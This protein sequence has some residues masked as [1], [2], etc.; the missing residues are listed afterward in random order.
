[1]KVRDFL[2]KVL[3][4]SIKDKYFNALPSLPADKD[5]VLE[6]FI[7][8]LNELLSE[9]GKKNPA[10]SSY[11]YDTSA[12]KRDSDL[13]VDYLRPKKGNFLT[14]FSVEF[15][16]SGGTVSYPLK[17][18]GISDF[19]ANS[20][21][22]TIQTLPS[23]YNYNIFANR[24]YIYPTPSVSGKINVFGKEAV[25]NFTES[26]AGLDK[27]FPSWVSESFLLFAQYYMAKEICSQY[28]AP[29][30]AQ[31]EEKL[32]TH[33]KALSSENNIVYQKLSEVKNFD[34]PIRNTRRGL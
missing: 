8:D 11:S 9:I 25:G 1:M 28:N 12:L 22:R 33:K 17:R 20:P 3:Y 32:T 7:K 31:K 13:N 34:L 29:W 2:E 24:L 10:Y 21:I 26:T 23:L 16:Y 4:L 14:I 18:V 6:P 5:T 15:N 19:F 30:Q 27:E